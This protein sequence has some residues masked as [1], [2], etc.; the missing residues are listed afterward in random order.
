MNCT[1]PPDELVAAFGEDREV[2]EKLAALEQAGCG[3]LNMLP[4]LI[5]ERTPQWPRATGAFLGL[6]PGMLARPGLLYRSAI[7]ASTFSLANG[8]QLYA[9]FP[10]RFFFLHCQRN[11]EFAS[12]IP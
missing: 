3:G 6:R 10:F 4:Y 8:I 7:E 1:G 9:A 12:H 5:G 2:L 11:M